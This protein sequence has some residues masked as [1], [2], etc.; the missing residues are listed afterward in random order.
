M[1][2]LFLL[3]FF[4]GDGCCRSKKSSLVIISLCS[5]ISV[6]ENDARFRLDVLLWEEDD[7]SIEFDLCISDGLCGVLLSGDDT[8]DDNLQVLD[9]LLTS[10]WSIW[11]LHLSIVSSLLEWS[12]TTSALDVQS[13]SLLSGKLSKLTTIIIIL[14]G[15]SFG[16]REILFVAFYETRVFEEGECRR[17]YISHI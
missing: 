6:V 13:G 3:F 11:S 14:L 12:I 7:F 9:T 8:L 4:A 2:T 17:T 5:T 10:W 16:S 15:L 1:F